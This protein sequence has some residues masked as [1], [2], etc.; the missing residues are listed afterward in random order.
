MIALI[1]MLGMLCRSTL[2]NLPVPV[3]HGFAGMV[4]LIGP[5]VGSALEDV[6]AKPSVE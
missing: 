1:R 2:L 5:F 3:S 6:A 4:G